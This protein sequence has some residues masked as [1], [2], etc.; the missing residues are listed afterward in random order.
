MRS[1]SNAPAEAGD[2]IRRARRR[3]PR[4]LSAPKGR[5]SAVISSHQSGRPPDCCGN[6]SPRWRSHFADDGRKPGLRR[7]RL[8]AVPAADAPDAR[9]SRD[10]RQPCPPSSR[11]RSA[12]AARRKI[13]KRFTDAS[14]PVIGCRFPSAATSSRRRNGSMA[15][16]IG[17]SV[18][19]PLFHGERWATAARRSRGWRQRLWQM[20]G[21]V[22]RDR[23][24]PSVRGVDGQPLD[25][26][27]S[28]R[29]QLRQH[30]RRP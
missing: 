15:P 25:D 26:A 6:F 10:H 24:R 16:A 1:T 5:V 30:G 19:S 9:P 18:H 14:Q 12:M 17:S 3:G 13:S 28:R 2:P 27:G 20:V 23:G 4:R 22:R 8:Q 29:T 11:N 7:R 21:R